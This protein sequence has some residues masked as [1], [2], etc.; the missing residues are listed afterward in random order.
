MQGI[1]NPCFSAPMPVYCWAYWLASILRKI[2][3]N[4]CMHGSE[5]SY[6]RIMKQFYLPLFSKPHCV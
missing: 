2:Y 1:F 3:Q 4:L 6:T 5:L